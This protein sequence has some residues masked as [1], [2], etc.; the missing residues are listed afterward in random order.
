MLPQSACSPE[1]ICTKSGNQLRHRRVQDLEF[2]TNKEAPKFEKWMKYSYTSRVKRWLIDSVPA[3]LK[4]FGLRTQPESISTA[5]KCPGSEFMSH[6]T[7]P[8]FVRFVAQ[9]RPF[10]ATG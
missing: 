8:M 7:W 6:S 1:H 9:R 4:L 10:E 2:Q 3:H 5:Q